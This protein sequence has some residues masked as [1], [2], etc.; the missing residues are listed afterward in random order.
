MQVQ[1]NHVDAPF[2]KS[3]Q[4]IGQIHFVGERERRHDQCSAAA[5]YI[6]QCVD[7]RIGSTLDGSEG[8]HRRVGQHDVTRFESDFAEA[9]DQLRSTNA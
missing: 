2:A 8:P 1:H 9:I 7:D 4:T 5:D 3:P 6:E